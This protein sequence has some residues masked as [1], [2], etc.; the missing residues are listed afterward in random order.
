MLIFVRVITAENYKINE[1]DKEIETK[2][3]KI[4]HLRWI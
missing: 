4:V 1:Y 2:W 3:K